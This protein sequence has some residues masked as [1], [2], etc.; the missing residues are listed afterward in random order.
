MPSSEAVTAI[1]GR[2]LIFHEDD[3][4]YW[5]PPGR[6]GGRQIPSV[7]Q[8]IK[9]VRVSEDFDA[10]EAMRPG[11]ITARRDLGS[12][13]HIDAHSYDDEDLDLDT[14]DDRVRP[15]LDAWIA[16]R[17]NFHAEP[18]QRERRVYHPVYGYCGTL[19][20][21]F[22][23]GGKN[24]LID[25]KTGS[26]ESA[27]AHLQTSAYQA[28]YAAEH[29]DTPIHE[30]WS[31]ELCPERSMPYRVVNYTLRAEGWRDWSK[32]QACLVV[33]WEQAARRGK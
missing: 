18:Q 25:L 13:V 16:W 9:A 17:E 27:G 2:T 1:T 30:R 29:P 10:I 12:A 6:T 21:I 32:F 26:P 23:I 22:T 28:A 5:T 31:V 19:D 11:V 8:I 15:Y 24:V 20:G 33:Y 4:S 7:T 3:H 14:V